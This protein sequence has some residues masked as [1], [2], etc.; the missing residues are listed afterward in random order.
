M[1]LSLIC[2]FW[3]IFCFFCFAVLVGSAGY[4]LLQMFRKKIPLRKGVGGLVSACI[5]VSAAAII[6]GATDKG[7]NEMMR[8][9]QKVRLLERDYPTVVE[10]LSN[11]EGAGVEEVSFINQYLDLYDSATE[12][13]AENHG[14]ISGML[15]RFLAPQYNITSKDIQAYALPV[16]EILVKSPETTPTLTASDEVTALVK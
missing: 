4:I 10:I 2:G 1:D 11:E 3:T 15:F 9:Q 16:D 5:M 7:P 13:L 12:T 14:S 8:I 6:F